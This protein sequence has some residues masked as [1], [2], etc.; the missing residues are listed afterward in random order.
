M[1]VH[2]FHNILFLICLITL[3]L[4][5]V[6]PINAQPLSFLVDSVEYVWPT[7]ATN[8][9]SS[10]FGETRSA[11]LHAGLDIRTWGQEGYKVFATRDGIIY[12]IGT[13]PHGYGNVLYM[14][15]NDGSYSVYAHL[16]RFE[17]NLQ[18][19][20]D[21][22]RIQDY[23]FVMNEVIEEDSLFYEKGEVIAFTGSSGVG[24]PHLHFE[25]RNKDNEPV[26]PL[27][28]NL[29]VRDNLPPVFR[30]LGIEFLN[31]I[32]LKNEGFEIKNARRDGRN[33]EFGEITVN[34][35]VGLSVNL[36]DRANNTPNAYAVYT[37]TLVHQSDTLYHSSV[38]QFSYAEGRHMFLDRS[39][40][41]LAETRR[42]FQRLY[43]V[44]GN[45]L[46]IYRKL[47][48]RG[49][50]AL[51]EGKY[52][53]Q[54]I[55]SDIF[56]NE[57]KAAVTLNVN[58]SNKIDNITDV[59][60]YPAPGEIS[61]PFTLNQKE[62]LFDNSV[63]MLASSEP[64]SFS[65]S[66]ISD[67]IRFRSNSS[68]EK[69][70]SPGIKQV[71][72]TPNQQLWIE[73]PKE[74]LYDSLNLHLDI[75]RIGDEIHFNFS[76]DRLPIEGEVYFN[77][78]LPDELKDNEHLGLFSVDKF[79]NRTY[80]MWATNKDGMIRSPLREISSLVIME[81]KTSPWVGKPHLEK[82]LAGNYVIRVPAV[83]R[84]TGIDYQASNIT[85][86]G[87]RGIIEYDPDRNSLFYYIP[88]YVPEN[89]NQVE[90]EVFD[91]MGNRTS[92]TE[93]FTF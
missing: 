9:I 55:A 88:G 53:L 23:S 86:N 83:D 54:I 65:I 72:S 27:L 6:H 85:V 63:P 92:K 33:Y 58:G 5:H 30:Q 34:Q 77:Y 15:H 57:T 80:F 41:I 20:T 11:H 38:D 39:Y 84:D 89:Q 70:L 76:P 16:N 64:I 22:I 56:G 19:Y 81:D 12:R 93:S 78:I 87:K 37:L 29:T 10:T 17:P 1:S 79:R 3:G 50:L 52:P 68:I 35:P 46:P 13:G 21:S 67:E 36:H 2:N 82:N 18:A 8:Q 66:R 25:I 48:N 51:D 32:N 59:P 14:K 44:N 91:G 74:A 47:K 26:N 60:T 71:F 7:D 62:V 69:R 49:V 31:P 28:T 42:A 43:K 40:Q 73:F 75:S 4:I 24:P 61:K 45:K 90:I